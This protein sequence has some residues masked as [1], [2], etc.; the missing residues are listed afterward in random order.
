MILQENVLVDVDEERRRMLRR[1]VKQSVADAEVLKR[2]LR[3]T[4][5][6]TPRPSTATTP[7][8]ENRKTLPFSLVRVH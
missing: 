3:E 8:V 7:P 1:K 2:R 5:V 4:A 6:T